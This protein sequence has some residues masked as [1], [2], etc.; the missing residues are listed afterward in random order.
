M[1]TVI[2]Y[3]LHLYLKI[4]TTIPLHTSLFDIYKLIYTYL[5]SMC[6]S[7]NTFYSDIIHNFSSCNLL[8]ITEA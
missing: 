2:D 5:K 8:N 3:G 6:Q 1:S 4:I 7:Y